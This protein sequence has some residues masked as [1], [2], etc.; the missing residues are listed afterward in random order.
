MPTRNRPD[1]LE[2]ALGSLIEATASVAEH[3]EVTV[4]DG[5]DDDA[6]GQVVR[7]LL[8][9]WPGG[10]RYVWNRPALDLPGNMNRATGLA[11]GDWILQFHD[12]DLL[13]PGAGKLVLDAIHHIRPDERVL[14]FGVEIVDLDGTVRGRQTFRRERYLAPREA[15][16]HVLRNS[17]FVRLPAIVVHRAAFEEVG[18]YDATLGPACDTDMWARLFCRYGVRCMP[19]ITCAYTVHQAATTTGMWNPGTIQAS[20]K[21]FDR[22][23]ARGIVPEHSIRR[24]EVDFFHQFILA[25]AYRRLRLWRRGEARDVLR[26]FDLPEIRDLGLSPKWL[27]LRVAFAVA[28][29]GVRRRA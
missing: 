24:W 13:K 5:S 18:G 8:A 23:A 4:S 20:R 15:L 1:L 28:T 2:R 7:R 29:A 9:D 19:Q 17:S 14:L 22:A 12:D 27:P 16:R 26:L 10:H 25:G 3:V 21:I 11:T 6:S